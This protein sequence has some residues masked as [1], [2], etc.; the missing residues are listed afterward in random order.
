MMYFYKK[1]ADN[2]EVV[3]SKIFKE[4]GK[5]IVRVYFERPVYG[6]FESAE[7]LLPDHEWK[8]DGYPKERLGQLKE[9][10]RSVE[11]DIIARAERIT[12]KKDGENG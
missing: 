6:D 1:L 4:S 2:T 8:N 7:C 5:N 3:H 10:L 12:R 11:E 9:Y